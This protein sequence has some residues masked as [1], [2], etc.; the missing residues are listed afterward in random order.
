V[1]L[2]CVEVGD[3]SYQCAPLCQ[4]AAVDC[5]AYAGARCQARPSTTSY[6][7]MVCVVAGP[8]SS[9][10][11]AKSCRDGQD[12][13]GDTYVDCDD[14][15]CC[16]F[17]DCSGRPETYCGRLENTM[18]RCTDGLDNDGDTYADCDDRDCCDIIY[19]A[20]QPDTY[21]GRVQSPN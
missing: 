20:D 19:C 16:P 2:D 15:D 5:A 3:G 1:D 7:T 18:I 13:D 4:S 12:N 11:D 14:R 17:I 8:L 10:K 9:V 6:E 21:C